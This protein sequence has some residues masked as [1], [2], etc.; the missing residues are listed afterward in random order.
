MRSNE[1][2]QS[3]SD[4]NPIYIGVTT[5]ACLQSYSLKF[6]RDNTIYIFRVENRI[7]AVRGIH[8]K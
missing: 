1:S 8:L 3:V 5:N 7:L 2:L 4:V 6:T